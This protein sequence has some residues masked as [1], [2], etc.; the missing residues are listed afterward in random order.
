MGPNA[1]GRSLNRR[2]RKHVRARAVG[3]ATVGG[4]EDLRREVPRKSG[5][6]RPWIKHKKAEKEELGKWEKPGK[7][8]VPGF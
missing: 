4:G 5:R 2:P 6:S 7:E 1:V 8:A 3:G